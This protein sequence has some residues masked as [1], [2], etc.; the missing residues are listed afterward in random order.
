MKYAGEVDWVVVGVRT[1][2]SQLNSLKRC[3]NISKEYICRDVRNDDVWKTVTSQMYFP[4]TWN[5]LYRVEII[6]KNKIVFPTNTYINE[7]RIFNLTYAMFVKSLVLSPYIAYNWTMNPSSITHGRISPQAF[8]NAGI[9]M[10]RIIHCDA[11][12]AYMQHYT[13]VFA[14]RHIIRAAMESL[15]HLKDK[16]WQVF[17]LSLKAFCLSSFFKKYGI[18]SLSWIVR[19]LTDGIKRKINSKQ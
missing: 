11:L 14:C 12:S 18:I 5:K 4:S 6:K 7:D 16:G 2:D 13:A 1:V 17:Y 8:L 9:E 10:D 15:R 3:W 19:Y